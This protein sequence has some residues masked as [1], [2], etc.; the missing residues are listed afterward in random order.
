MNAAD[1]QA[2]AQELPLLL[3]ALDLAADKHASEIK[4]EAYLWGFE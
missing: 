2:D 1:A 3:A 4:H